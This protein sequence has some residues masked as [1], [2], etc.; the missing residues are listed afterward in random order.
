MPA[1]DYDIGHTNISTPPKDW[2]SKLETVVAPGEA[3][4]HGETQEFCESAFGWH[5]DSYPFVVVTMLSDCT[6]MQ[7]GE[8]AI[9]TGSGEVIKARGPSLVSCH[10]RPCCR[11]SATDK[12]EGYRSRIAGS[13]R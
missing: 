3:D 9:R 6:G 7:G 13:L 1:I 8:T 2:D 5:R 11:R 10:P 4:A 12:S